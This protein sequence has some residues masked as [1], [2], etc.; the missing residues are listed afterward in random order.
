MEN[1]TGNISEVLDDVVAGT[2]NVLMSVSLGDFGPI[3]EDTATGIAG[4]LG[5]SIAG[6]KAKAESGGYS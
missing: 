1:I 6:I 4:A 3:E 2:L 5:K